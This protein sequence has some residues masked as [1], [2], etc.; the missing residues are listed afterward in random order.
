MGIPILWIS[1]NTDQILR[2]INGEL[3]ILTLRTIGLG[4]A[5]ALVAI[6]FSILVSLANRWSKNVFVKIITFSSGIGYAIPG[7]VLAISLLTLVNSRFYFLPI[8]LL[9]WGYT[10]RF[11]TISKGSL[12]SSLERISPN[13]DEAATGL[14][15]NKLRVIRDIHIPL[16]RGPILVGGL[17]VFVDTIK[18][19]PITFLLRP[20]DFD[21]LS[22]RIFQY[23]GDERMAESIIPGLIVLSLG[24]LASIALMPSIDSKKT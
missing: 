13:I 10:D 7:T 15:A 9:I 3:L 4:V 19:L 5:T 14:G 11:L 17:L 2:G 18:E 23:A 1:L 22:V 16:L 12:D 20:F 8:L 21:T 24:L 6:I